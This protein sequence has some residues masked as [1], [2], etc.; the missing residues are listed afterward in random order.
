MSERKYLFNDYSLF[1]VIRTHRNSINDAVN[2]IPKNQFKI[3][4]DTEVI[5]YIAS[6]MEME[7]LVLLEGQQQMHEPSECKVDVSGD[8]SRDFGSRGGPTY[9]D[10][11]SIRIDIPFTGPP[12][13]W[14]CEPD[15]STSCPPFGNVQR[16]ASGNG[17]TLVISYMQ[18]GDVDPKRLK[19]DYDRNIQEIK[20]YIEWQTAQ[21]KRFNDSLIPPIK[22]AVQHRR[23]LLEKQD[24]IADIFGI[25]MKPKDGAVNFEPIPVRKNSLS[26]FLAHQR[27][28]VRRNPVFRTRTMT[29]LWASSNTREHRSKR[30]LGHTSSI[31]KKS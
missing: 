8:R 4:P 18:P 23:D 16:A 29:T 27:K 19:T 15:S 7:P 1:D 14:F 6:S 28:G 31:V 9:V 20:R 17:G 21:I 22:C 11:H 5:A 10:G 26:H 25:P 30:P 12:D 2:R 13:L 3:T 24:G